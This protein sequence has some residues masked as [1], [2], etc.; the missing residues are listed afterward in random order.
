MRKARTIRAT[1]S[2]SNCPRLPQSIPFHQPMGRRP[3]WVSAR[4]PTSV[5][6]ERKAPL[7][8]DAIVLLALHD[9]CQSACLRCCYFL[10]CV[11]SSG[12]ALGRWRWKIGGGCSLPNVHAGSVGAPEGN[13]AGAIRY[14]GHVF[15]VGLCVRMPVFSSNSECSS[16]APR[17]HLRYQ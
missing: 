13:R 3:A 15:K 5:H 16:D 6:R 10:V 11:V 2:C 7:P 14:D 17:W 1:S 4:K 9:L 12:L 8:T